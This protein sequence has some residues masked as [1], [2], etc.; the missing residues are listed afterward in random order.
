MFF[1]FSAF[2]RKKEKSFDWKQNMRG[3]KKN[4]RTKKIVTIKKLR[5]EN[6]RSFDR[7][8]FN[9]AS[10]RQEMFVSSLDLDF[11][12]KSFRKKAIFVEEVIIGFANKLL[13]NPQP[14][15]VHA[16]LSV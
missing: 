10:W 1:P 12:L 9:I 8:H 5:N 16:N 3:K 4:V 15:Q 2:S 6:L 14:V 13:V 7:K 11:D